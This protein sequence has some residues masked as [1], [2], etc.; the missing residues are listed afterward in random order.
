MKGI[1]K[2]DHNFPGVLETSIEPACAPVVC[3]T[4]QGTTHASQAEAES[5]LD[6]VGE[7]LATI[8][9]ILKATEHFY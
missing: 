2:S 6:R 3:R 5:A 8:V 9:G 4:V 1:D 7:S